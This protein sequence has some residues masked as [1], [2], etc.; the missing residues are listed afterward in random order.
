MVVAA[1]PSREK[2]AV[3]RDVSAVQSSPEQGRRKVEVLIY[4]ASEWVTKC[5]GFVSLQA[6]AWYLRM[7]ILQIWV[8]ER[9]AGIDLLRERVVGRS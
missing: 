5:L 4:P 8:H 2:L 9:I 7:C 6:V 1:V 3:G